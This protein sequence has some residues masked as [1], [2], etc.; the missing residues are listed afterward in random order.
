MILQTWL[1]WPSIALVASALTLLAGGAM[2]QD[3]G[4][5][6]K[7]YD[8]TGAKAAP[9]AC[10]LAVMG[11][12]VPPE[13][14]KSGGGNENTASNGEDS[15]AGVTCL[16]LNDPSCRA[17][18]PSKIANAGHVAGLMR[19]SA[20]KNPAHQ[21]AKIVEQP[22]STATA[23]A[24]QSAVMVALKIEFA[25]NSADLTDAAK[26]SLDE[27]AKVI[28]WQVNQG[29]TWEVQGHT[30]ASG[31]PKHN[32]ELSLRRAEAA[33]S[34]LH[35]HDGVALSQLKPMAMGQRALLYPDR[36]YDAANRRVQIGHLGT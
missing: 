24:G 34:Y 32:D 36:P 16:N 10:D 25:L 22:E 3:A 26:R 23:K 20:P 14:Q 29:L 13:C 19:N 1:R 4:K 12:A 8:F 2:A 9:T 11:K 35:E 15:G 17:V 5:S 18:D 6:I 7:V 27:V 28:K 31:S 30:D 33:I 21:E